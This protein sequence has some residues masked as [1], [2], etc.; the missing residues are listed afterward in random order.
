LQCHQAAPAHEFLETHW[1][2]VLL[3]PCGYWLLV[4]PVQQKYLQ[5]THLPIELTYKADT[6]PLKLPTRHAPDI[7]ILAVINCTDVA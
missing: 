2:S 3:T 5:S 6:C 1:E 4:L 7:L